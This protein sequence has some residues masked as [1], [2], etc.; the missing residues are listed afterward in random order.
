MYKK[1]YIRNFIKINLAPPRETLKMFG[2]YLSIEE[3]RENSLRND[4]TF[5]V[6]IPPLISIIPKIEENISNTT[7][8]TKNNYPLVNE[9]ILN[10]TH[11]TLKLKRNKPVTNPNSTLQSFMDLKII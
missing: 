4:K 3:F 1:L 9:S 6:I 5:S 7:K 11:N 10:K 2:G 8:N